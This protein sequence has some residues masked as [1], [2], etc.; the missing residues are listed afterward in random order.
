MVT[1]G[2]DLG[3]KS[4]KSPKNTEGGGEGG[5]GDRMGLKQTKEGGR[6]GVAQGGG[7]ECRVGTTLKDLDL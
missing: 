7:K 1:S 4:P 2:L 6:E 5:G 3:T